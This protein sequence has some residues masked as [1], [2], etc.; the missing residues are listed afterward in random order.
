MSGNSQVDADGGP[1]FLAGDTPVLTIALAN[2]SGPITDLLTNANYSAE[3]VI[4]GPTDD[5]QRIAYAVLAPAS[6]ATPGGS[7]VATATPGTYT[8]T[9]PGPLPA[10]PLAP[11]NQ[12]FPIRPLNPAGTYTLWTWIGE[13]L[14]ST[15]G[16]SH[17]SIV[18]VPY[19]DV[20][21]W[22]QDFEFG[23]PG[24]I[25]PRQVILKSA[26]NSCHAN[27]THHDG[28]RM[29]PEQCSLCH[30]AGSVDGTAGP[31]M[32]LTG[33]PPVA[34]PGDPC[35]TNGDADCSASWML[36]YNPYPTRAPGGGS[37]AQCYIAVDPTPGPPI[38]FAKAVGQ[39]GPAC[40]SATEAT[41]CAGLAAGWEGCFASFSS[42]SSNL[43]CTSGSPSCN[44][45]VTVD[46]TPGLPVDF[47][48][49]IHNIHFARLRAGY[50]ESNNLVNPGTL[51][52][53]GATGGVDD[54]SQVLFPQD[55]RNCTMCH[56]STNAPCSSS[57]PCGV[58]QTCYSP[59][60][61]GVASSGTCVNTSWQFPSAMVCTTCH[62]SEAAF[63]H[64]ATN[65]YPSPAG[66][67]PLEACAACHG[68]NPDGTVT[69]TPD[70]SVAAVHNITSPYV[71]PYDRVPTTP[72]P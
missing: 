13:N 1:V 33:G 35:E 20:G 43:P 46:P 50:A 18:G 52:E 34:V 21:N 58:G 3:A 49:F 55:V 36:C 69:T 7:L 64:A 8:Y 44:C 72:V 54:Y 68:P 26:C 63:V 61:M 5:R 40:T 11:A 56:A 31:V 9:F 29:E 67:A 27:L 47:R 48:V 65:T 42:A 17:G 28:L 30:T 32:P 53:V 71:P 41:D 62:D 45:Y 10:A 39:R 57:A 14:L 15:Q 12:P 4:G 59:D 16:S 6:D 25:L 38:Y 37:G 70:F 66:G 23:A 2:Q 24:P 19:V 51:V 22:V 60:S